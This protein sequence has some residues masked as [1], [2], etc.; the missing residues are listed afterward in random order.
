MNNPF[1]HRIQN[2]QVEE[3]MK[4]LL[5]LVCSGEEYHGSIT[6]REFNRIKEK[7]KLRT[8]ILESI[9]TKPKGFFI[10][11]RE[12]NAND[13]FT[14]PLISFFG[15]LV[16]NNLSLYN[17][18]TKT[19]ELRDNIRN[20]TIAFEYANLIVDILRF[21]YFQGADEER[22]TQEELYDIMV[23]FRF[24]IEYMSTSAGRVWFTQISNIFFR[25]VSEIIED[26]EQQE[27][28]T[29]GLLCRLQHPSED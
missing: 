12:P 5:D 1:K 24:I 4:S 14:Q 2:K 15:W 9:Y 11:T 23:D 19:V 17:L 18:I 25:I 7:Y 6:N 3:T 16:M 20:S 10:K 26:K 29:T 28:L 8:D 21:A 22:Y 27:K 13:S